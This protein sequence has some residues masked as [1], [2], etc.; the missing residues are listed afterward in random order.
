MRASGLASDYDGE[1]EV[2]KEVHISGAEGIFEENEISRAVNRYL[3]R[4][5]SHSR[6]QPDKIFI[7]VERFR[8][9]PVKIP[10]LTI[11]TLA[12]ETPLEARGLI[13]KRLHSLG[14]SN[15]AIIQA[16]SIICSPSAMRGAAIIKMH[17]GDRSDPDIARGVRV[18]RLGID[19]NESAKLS[20]KLAKIKINTLRVKEAL[21]L[22]SKVAHHKDIIA[23]VCISDDPGY[24]TGY[25]ASKEFGYL[26]IPNIKNHG[27]MNGG[28]IFFIEEDAD[29][30]GLINY[31]E[32]TPVIIGGKQR[33]ESE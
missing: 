3:K 22:A 16:F 18:S 26:R 13:I 1:K 2:I 10:P 14:I 15:D 23:E 4:A 11:A 24:T 32:K 8:Q 5:M 31:L 19:K 33:L 6:G 17:T 21:I 20:R 30:P 28:R 9:H 7:T 27:D 29:V 25:L 12:C